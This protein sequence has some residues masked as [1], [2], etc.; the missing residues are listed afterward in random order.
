MNTQAAAHPPKRVQKLHHTPWT[1]RARA[2]RALRK[3]LETHDHVTPHF[4]WA[5]FACHDPQRTPV[6]ADLRL[7]TIRLCWL[8]EKQGAVRW[9]PYSKENAQQ[10]TTNATQTPAARYRPPRVPAGS[11]YRASAIAR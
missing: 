10:L 5:E 1:V 8:L 2:S 9:L 11:G 6:P 7:N 3:H 4:T